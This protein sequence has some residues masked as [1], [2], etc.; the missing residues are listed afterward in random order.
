VTQVRRQLG[1]LSVSFFA[2]SGLGLL[3]LVAVARWLTP[4]E[5]AHFQ[6]VWGLVFA[7]GSVLG[8]VEQ[9]VIRRSTAANLDGRRT[10][11]GSVQ[12]IALAALASLVV[13]GVVLATPQGRAV[14]QE[15]VPVALLTLLSVLNFAL[16]VLAR[17][18]LLGA[19]AIRGYAALL[20]GEALLR[21]VLIAVLVVAGVEATVEWAVL[22]TV[23]GSFVW[24]GALG[25]LARSVDWSS[26]RDPWS[27]VGGTVAALGIANGLSALV[28]TGFPAVAAVVLGNP[29]DLAVLFAVITLARAPLALLAPVQA[30]TVPT[31][32]RWSRSGDTARLSRA[33]QHIAAG[34]AASALAGAVVGYLVG[35][36]AVALVLGADYRP[37]PVV[38]AL[39]AAATCVMAGALLQ[40]AALV[41]LQR[42]WQL[43]ACWTASI[44]SAAF[45][46][47][48]APWDA[49]ARGL[50]GFTV[51]SAVAFLAT[52]LAV[53]HTVGSAVARAEQASD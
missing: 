5:N 46:M 28:L 24:L 42:Y 48:A 50:G 53:R 7:F 10:P 1:L 4:A 52:A 25:R 35:P 18:I 26:G 2:A 49:E 21:V 6:A 37:G 29:A 14:V 40:A 12:A 51:A 34:S 38:A 44:A 27:R 33:L 3:L 13:L 22:V 45:V 15:S 47:L 9:E 16:L 39:V 43:T 36:W 20:V 31:V 8:S 17:G 23:A 30:M 11:V 41:A 32:V 19:H